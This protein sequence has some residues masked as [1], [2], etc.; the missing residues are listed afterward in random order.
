MLVHSHPGY[1]PGRVCVQ[2]CSRSWPASKLGTAA[3]RRAIALAQARRDAPRPAPGP[4]GPPAGTS[5]PVRRRAGFPG[6]SG[7][8][9]QPGPPG[10]LPSHDRPVGGCARIGT[11]VSCP[12]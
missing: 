11:V 3:R 12:N 4:P 1:P 5:A 7:G 2:N 6:G 10:V 8:T 9:R